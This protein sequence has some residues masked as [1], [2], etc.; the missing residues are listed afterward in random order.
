MV[1]VSRQSRAKLYIYVSSKN[2][3]IG[4]ESKT[5]KEHKTFPIWQKYYKYFR[6]DRLWLAP[7]QN[8]CFAAWELD[9]AKKYENGIYTNF[10][11]N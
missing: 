10:R 6:R 4:E 7:L 5:L 1:Q 3:D 11:Q 2:I 8:F 9:L